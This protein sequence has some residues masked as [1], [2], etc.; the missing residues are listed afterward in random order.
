MK[1]RRLSILV[2]LVLIF[3][4]I[5][6]PSFSASVEPKPLR[7][8]FVPGHGNYAIAKQWAFLVR[9]IS[10]STGLAVELVIGENYKDLYE[11][12]RKGDLDILEGAAYLQGLLIRDGLGKPLVGEVKKGLYEYR[13]AIVVR[14]DSGIK[15]ISGLKSTRLA[16]TDELSTSGFILPRIYFEEQ[17]I[18]D[19]NS[20]F[21]D[22]T[23]TGSHDRSLDFLFNGDV[24]VV[25]VGEYFL[26]Y[27][28]PADK[29]KLRVLGYSAAYP[30]GPITYRVGIDEKLVSRLREALL[31][32]ME[33]IP[34]ET[35]QRSYSDRFVPFRPSYEKV[36]LDLGLRAEHFKQ[37]RYSPPPREGPMR[38]RWAQQKELQKFKNILF[39]FAVLFFVLIILGEALRAQNLRYRWATMGMRVVFL[40]VVFALVFAHVMWRARVGLEQKAQAVAASVGVVQDTVLDQITHGVTGITPQEARA[41]IQDKNVFNALIDFRVCRNGYY[42]IDSTGRSVSKPIIDNLLSDAFA[43]NNVAHPDEMEIL[44]PLWVDNQ[45]W[46][47]LQILLSFKVLHQDMMRWQ[48]IAFVWGAGLLLIYHVSWWVWKKR[49]PLVR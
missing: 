48:V 6:V 25:A 13:A 7:I 5:S 33:E 1:I 49:L 21:S 42:W 19:L 46:G 8:G 34:F 22:I 45:V 41:L 16:L 11:S 24:D 10:N 18:Q 12:F 43:L 27:L 2:L 14:V 47:T 31:K 36:L 23:L 3:V 37:L 26:D 30:M 4:G 38:I 9:Y 29:Q 44:E 35:M 32:A 28:E 17:G 20:F 39:V 40:L 15:N